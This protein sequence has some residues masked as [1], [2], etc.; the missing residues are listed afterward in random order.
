M[1]HLAIIGTFALLCVAGC[2]DGSKNDANAPPPPVNPEL[3]AAPDILATMAAAYAKCETYADAGT[4]T[5]TLTTSDG[6][7]KAKSVKPFT[8]SFVR[9]GGFRFQFSESDEPNSLY[10]VWTDGKSVLTWWD[11]N[12][13]IESEESLGL[14][15]AGATGVSSGS[16]HTIPSLLI[17]DQVGGRAL[18]AITHP[19][20]GSDSE[21]D[22][23]PCFVIH[24]SYGDDPITLWIEK[25]TYLI[26]RIDSES[27]FDEFTSDDSTIYS[28]SFDSKIDPEK[29]AFGIPQ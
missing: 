24:G 2:S 10:V 21:I 8:T 7:A 11:L 3:P 1:R 6:I 23:A 12:Q 28:A 17:P 29:L 16:A 5:T 19:T 20:R 22:A 4:A 18:T 15:L 13:K 25:Q 26:R 14:A 27:T 9:N